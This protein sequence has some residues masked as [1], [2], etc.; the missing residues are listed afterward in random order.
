MCG[1]H[2]TGSLSSNEGRRIPRSWRW[3][4]LPGWLPFS[5]VA[6]FTGM[7]DGA[8]WKRAFT[9]CFTAPQKSHQPNPNGP[10]TQKCWVPKSPN[11]TQQTWRCF[12]PL[13]THL[14][15]LIKELP[16]PKTACNRLKH[17]IGLCKSSLSR[18]WL[19]PWKYSAF[20]SGSFLADGEFLPVVQG[21]V[22]SAIQALN[23]P[24]YEGPKLLGTL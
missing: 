14:S 9:K 8:P 11:E 19:G 10:A 5:G 2:W 20:F 13:Q 7:C 23:L 12:T 1:I 6:G 22:T 3:M 18:H 24:K 16:D 17:H 15:C 21:R 4:N